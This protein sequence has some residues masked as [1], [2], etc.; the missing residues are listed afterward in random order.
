MGGIDTSEGGPP[1]S[2]SISLSQANKILTLENESIEL[3]MRL[4]KLNAE[5]KKLEVSFSFLVSEPT[6]NTSNTKHTHTTQT[7]TPPF[8]QTDAL[9]GDGGGQ[10]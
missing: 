2:K 9:Q 7:Q 5:H 4:E 1:Q 3:Q 8:F 10:E 6:Q